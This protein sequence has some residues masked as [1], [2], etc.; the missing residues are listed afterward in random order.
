MS[1][2]KQNTCHVSSCPSQNPFIFATLPERDVTWNGA[3]PSVTQLEEALNIGH[4]GL[5]DRDQLEMAGV[6]LE[7][8]SPSYRHQ[9]A[10]R[11]GPEATRLARAGY[12]LNLATR[13]L[14]HR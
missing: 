4:T 12:M 7:M 6:H 11:T 8:N 10:M 1:C 9:M 13:H 5:Q 14:A 3:M 2:K